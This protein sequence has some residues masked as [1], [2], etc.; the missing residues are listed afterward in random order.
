MT[1]FK[2]GI[3]LTLLL[4]S[5]SECFNNEQ[6]GNEI[7]RVSLSFFISIT[8]LLDDFTF[9]STSSLSLQSTS[10]SSYFPHFHSSFFR[11]FFLSTLLLSFTL[12]FS[13]SLHLSLSFSSSPFLSPSPFISLSLS[14][15]PFLP[16][17]LSPF[18]PS[19]Y[20]S[21]S[22]Y[23]HIQSLEKSSHLWSNF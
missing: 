21:L 17:P 13:I 22:V 9:F 18:S 14:S 8:L 3:G 11:V 16:L 20:L 19:L 6:I 5:F 1:K 12:P 4:W 10:D 2:M 7:W 23:S 15:S